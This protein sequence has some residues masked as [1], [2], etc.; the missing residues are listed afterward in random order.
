MPVF[1]VGAG[2]TIGLIYDILMY[3]WRMPF[4]GL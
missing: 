3:A 4:M 2:L 1:V